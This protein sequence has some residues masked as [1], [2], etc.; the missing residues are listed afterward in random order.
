LGQELT[1]G[2]GRVRPGFLDA[3]A[4][5][6]HVRTLFK[7]LLNRLPQGKT[8]LRNCGHTPG[9]REEYKPCGIPERES[10]GFGCPSGYVHQEKV[11]ERGIHYIR[12]KNNSP[13]AGTPS[14]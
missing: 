4:R 8:F 5:Y 13:R 1:A 3:G 14:V 7:S 9:R 12:R 10:H 2:K 11:T 6:I